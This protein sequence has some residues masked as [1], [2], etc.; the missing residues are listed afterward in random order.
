VHVDETLNRFADF[1]L[2][3]AQKFVSQPGSA[4]TRWGSYSAPPD[5]IAFIRGRRGG[6]ETERAGNMEGEGEGRE[7]CEG[8]GENAKRKG[9]MGREG[10]GG[11]GGTRERK[12]R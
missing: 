11:K 4:R 10:G 6:K 2:L 3:I 7:E 5:P 12:G 1:G 8:V 9:E